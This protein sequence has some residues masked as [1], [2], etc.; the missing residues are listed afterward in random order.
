MPGVP[1]SRPQ[2]KSATYVGRRKGITLGWVDEPP[3]SGHWLG[4]QPEA[5]E[6]EVI[7]LSLGQE[8]VWRD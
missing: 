4:A 5:K 6:F 3:E 2:S 1:P 8:G 7:G